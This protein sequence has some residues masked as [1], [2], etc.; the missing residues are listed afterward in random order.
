MKMIDP[1]EFVNS[2]LVRLH[3]VPAPAKLG[4]ARDTRWFAEQPG[5]GLRRYASGR[6][7]EALATGFSPR[8]AAISI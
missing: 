2:E 7:G 5:F 3:I 1:K 6:E 8:K 4:R